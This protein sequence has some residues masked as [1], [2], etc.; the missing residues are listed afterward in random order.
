MIR[1]YPLN[2]SVEMSQTCSRIN[3]GGKGV[4]T[5][6]V[7]RVEQPDGDIRQYVYSGFCPVCHEVRAGSFFVKG[8]DMTVE[9]ALSLAEADCLAQEIVNEWGIN[10][11]AGNG[12]ALT[13]EFLNAFERAC[14]YQQVRERTIFYRERIELP[15]SE[16]QAEAAVHRAFMDAYQ[17]LADKLRLRPV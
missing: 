17:P 14:Q 1:E 7:G 16:L 11:R 13:S 9:N 2:V 12:P 6:T 5:N 15:E 3:C 8:D 10:M 4:Q